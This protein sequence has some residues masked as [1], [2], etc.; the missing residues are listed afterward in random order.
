MVEFSEREG[1][2]WGPPPRKERRKR[3]DVMEKEVGQRGRPGEASGSLG[4]PMG[5]SGVSVV[6][7]RRAPG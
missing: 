5:S 1:A 6:H 4:D 3:E 7:Q 2:Y